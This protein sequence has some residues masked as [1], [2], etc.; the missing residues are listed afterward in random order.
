MKTKWT[1]VSPYTGMDEDAPANNAGSGN[2]SFDKDDVGLGNLANS[3]QVDLDL[4]N[5]P[6]AI[7]NAQVTL[8]KD[9]SGIL[10]LN[11]AGSG[12]VSFDNSDVGLGNVTNDAQIKT[13]GSNAPKNLKNTQKKIFN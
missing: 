6:D 7:K 12:N 1:V 8:A 13:D 4:G 3:R 10:S 5:A 11:N 2:V 9:G